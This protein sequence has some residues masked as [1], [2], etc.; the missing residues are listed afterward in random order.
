MDEELQ[1]IL[2]FENKPLS[3]IIGELKEKS[4]KLQDWQKLLVDYEPTLHPILSDHENLKD[5]HRKDGTTEKSSRICIGLEKLLTKRFKEFTFAIPVKR[6]Y[7]NINGN[8]TRQEIVGAIEAVYKNAHI[9]NENL[10]RGLMLYASCSIFTIWYAVRK[11]NDLYGFHSNFKLKCKTYSPMNGVTL[12]PLINELD[13]MLAM[14]FGYTKTIANKEV[15]YF[16][17]YTDTKHYIW[18]K[19]LSTGGWEA[20]T[21]N[22]ETGEQGEDII[23]LGK[24]P[25]VFAYL[26]QPVYFGLTPLRSEI[27]YTLSRNG[28]VIAYNASPIIKVSGAVKGE[29]KKGESSRVWR[30]ENGGDVSYVSWNQAIEALKYHVDTMLKLYWM[31]AQIPDIS[32]ENMKGLGSIGFDARQTLLMDA[33]LKVGDVSGLWVEFF[34]RECNVIKA[35]LSILNPKWAKEMPNVVVDHII[36]PYVQNDESAQVSVRMKANGGKPIESQLESIERFGKSSNAQATLE[37]I[38]KEDLAEAK[39]KADAFN[40]DNQ[41]V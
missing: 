8:A 6:V 12:Y 29:E 15:T 19:S 13:D 5:K 2:D 27:E 26:P 28:N 40:I 23:L 10:K 17:T 21:L 4:V 38:Q 32:F 25:G 1:D 11:E 36:T 3:Q 7:S 33:H 18:R 34:E 9:N 16:E 30:T 20:V 41:T 39:S 24:I 37:Q 14:S 22:S 35:F 31:Q